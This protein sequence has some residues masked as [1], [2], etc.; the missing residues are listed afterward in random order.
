MNEI[1]SN[2][3]RGPE[4]RQIPLWCVIVCC[5]VVL[6]STAIGL[7]FLAISQLPTS[8]HGVA[9]DALTSNLYQR[10]VLSTLGAALIGFSLAVLGSILLWGYLLL[11]KEQP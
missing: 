5:G 2:P 4:K 7:Y 1:L 8:E 3:P 10:A 6:C 9:A 11:R